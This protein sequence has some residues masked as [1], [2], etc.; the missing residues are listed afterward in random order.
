MFYV[1]CLYR[2]VVNTFQ[3][4]K[5]KV[6]IQADPKKK[7]QP[8]QKILVNVTQFTEVRADASATDKKCP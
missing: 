4:T 5:Q 6:M 7:I 2:L 1:M 8:I 3:K